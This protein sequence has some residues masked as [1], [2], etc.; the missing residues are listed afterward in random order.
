MLRWAAMEALKIPNTYF[1]KQFD[2]QW[3]HD[4]G[5][6]NRQIDFRC[7]DR[8]VF[9]MLKTSRQQVLS[10][11]SDHRCVQA[12]IVAE[13]IVRNK[14]AARVKA[15][16]INMARISKT[17]RAEYMMALEQNMDDISVTDDWLYHGLYERYIRGPKIPKISHQMFRT[18]IVHTSG[19]VCDFFGLIFLILGVEKYL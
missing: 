17:A 12:R 7:M 3:T 11:W 19:K 2:N 15:P 16:S 6:R 13:T 18:K 5:G 4:R 8:P 10:V 14:R 1:K 9:R